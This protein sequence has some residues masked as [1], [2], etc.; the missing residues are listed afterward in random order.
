MQARVAMVAQGTPAHS[1]NLYIT[2]SQRL[3]MGE[4]HWHHRA[5][6]QGRH[7]FLCTPLPWARIP[8][9]GVVSLWQFD[10]QG[11]A[12]LSWREDEKKATVLKV[13]STMLKG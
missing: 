4:S 6:S 10:A 2:P 5:H 11:K 9:L 13:K 3:D 1:A 7:Q 8:P 12:R